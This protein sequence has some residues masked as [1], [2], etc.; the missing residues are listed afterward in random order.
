MVLQNFTLA[1][2]WI[3]SVFSSVTNELAKWDFLG[4]AIVGLVFLKV[5]S[6]LYQKIFKGR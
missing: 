3:L 6:R 2:Q 5:I 4:V 1:Y